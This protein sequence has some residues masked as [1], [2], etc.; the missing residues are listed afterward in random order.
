MLKT[1]RILFFLALVVAPVLLRG[2]VTK[3][4]LRSEVTRRGQRASV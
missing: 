2:K 4:E 3:V 1:W